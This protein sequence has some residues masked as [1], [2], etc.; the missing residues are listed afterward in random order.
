VLVALKGGRIVAVLLFAV[1][2]S[3]VQQTYINDGTTK[4]LS[5][6]KTTVAV[7]DNKKSSSV[8]RKRE[9]KRSVKEGD[10]SLIRSTGY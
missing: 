10:L 2:Y 6:S 7:D 5:N 9:P 4:T 1:V 8:I 3:R